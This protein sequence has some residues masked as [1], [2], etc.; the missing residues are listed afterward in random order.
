MIHV[1]LNE[2]I[3]TIR[4]LLAKLLSVLLEFNKPGRLPIENYFDCEFFNDDD[5]IVCFFSVTAY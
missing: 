2:S 3:Y 1:T 5:I 4:F